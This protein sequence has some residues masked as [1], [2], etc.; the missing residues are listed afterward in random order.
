MSPE[1]QSKLL[2]CMKQTPHHR[3]LTSEK[4]KPFSHHQRVIS[5]LCV[6]VSLLRK[7]NVFNYSSLL[8]DFPCS[9]FIYLSLNFFYSCTEKSCVKYRS[10]LLS[11]KTVKFPFFQTKPIRKVEL[12]KSMRLNEFKRISHCKIYNFSKNILVHSLVHS[13]HV[14]PEWIWPQREWLSGTPADEVL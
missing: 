11:C 9:T 7:E 13:S 6:C 1:L 3:S 8:W 12:L 4:R 2:R 5:S 14:W 10:T